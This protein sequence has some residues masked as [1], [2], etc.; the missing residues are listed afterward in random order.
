MYT[1]DEWYQKA[2][3][4]PEQTLLSRAIQLLIGSV[5]M[6]VLLHLFS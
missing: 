3:F 4:S 2:G 6:Y 1:P 5:I